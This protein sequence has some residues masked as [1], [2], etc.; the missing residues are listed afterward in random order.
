M[1]L[2]F[3]L[4]LALAPFASAAGPASSDYGSEVKWDIL[5]AAKHARSEVPD[6]CLW[7]AEAVLD[8]KGDRFIGHFWSEKESAYYTTY[9]NAHSQTAGD[10]TKGDVGGSPFCI[11]DVPIGADRAIAIAM[12]HGL[13]LRVE[14]LVSLEL[15]KI[16]KE[17]IGNAHFVYNNL[18]A[19]RG[20]MVW[21]AVPNDSGNL[22]DA[23]VIE[24]VAGRFLAHGDFSNLPMGGD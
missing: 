7:K 8:P 5:T 17:S 20:R 15:V 6:A 1:P 10:L 22:S 11:R 21:I 3:A 12:K 4:L 2:S 23:W 9:V 24:A 14:P 16:E 13:K 18:R 19:A